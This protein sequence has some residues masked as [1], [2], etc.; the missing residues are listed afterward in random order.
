MLPWYQ[1]TLDWICVDDARLRVVGTAPLPPLEE[2]TREG[3][4]PSSDFPSDHVALVA[5]V[6]WRR[7]L[8]A[9]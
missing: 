3:A 9:E 6:A 5:D 1:N 4:I 8:K 2:L 7:S